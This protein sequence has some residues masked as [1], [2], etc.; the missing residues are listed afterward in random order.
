[1]ISDAFIK[2][3]DMVFA[4]TMR[5]RFYIIY[6]EKAIYS[7]HIFERFFYISIEYRNKETYT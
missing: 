7:Y 4:V 2:S 5:M 1:M 3:R 6:P